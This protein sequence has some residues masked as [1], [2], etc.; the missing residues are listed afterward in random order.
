MNSKWACFL[1][2]I[3]ILG[4][5]AVLLSSLQTVQAQYTED[6]QPFI[7]VSPISIVSPANQTYSSQPLLLNIT[8]KSFLDSSKANITIAYSI[9]GEANST[10]N[11]EAIPVPLGVQSYYVMN[12]FAT[13]R[14]MPEGTHYITVYGKYEFPMVYHGVA[15]DNRTI[16]LTIN[17]GNPPVITLLSVENKTYSQ[18]NLQIN[19]RTDESTAWTG[20]CLDK[21]ANATVTENLT[22]TE[23]SPGSHTLTLYAN[24]TAGNMGKSE[25]VCFTI[26]R[27]F[28]TLPTL[29]GM[30]IATIAKSAI[31]LRHGKNQKRA[32]S[33]NPQHSAI[34]LFEALQRLRFDSPKEKLIETRK[35][36]KNAYIF[37]SS[38]D[39]VSLRTS[40]GT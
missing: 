30:T 22:L 2:E 20:F 38:F 18:S 15:Y 4:Y 36:S 31:F 5:T 21:N 29:A 10:I 3:I 33:S 11:T 24:D 9:D 14:E 26:A 34:T 39:A 28:P 16:C 12:G 13:L 32:K 7:L 19:F 17:D 8:F 23:L 37:G 35:N 25:T 6:G 27:P 40:D 1:L